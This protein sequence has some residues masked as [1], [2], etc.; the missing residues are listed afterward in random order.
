MLDYTETDKN[1]FN[2]AVAGIT[3]GQPVFVTMSPDPAFLFPALPLVHRIV[4]VNGNVT[5]TELCFTCT[6]V[7]NAGSA[8]IAAVVVGFSLKKTAT[9][10]PETGTTLNSYNRTVISKGL[11][12]SA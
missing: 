7:Q 11:Q 9:Y 4:D 10:N 5:V 1:L 8:S 3:N 6:S 2:A 12:F